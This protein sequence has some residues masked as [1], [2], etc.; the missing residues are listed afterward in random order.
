MD[1][2]VHGQQAEGPVRRHTDEAL[3]HGS[4]AQGGDPV[5]ARL[6]FLRN[7]IEA[8]ETQG[9]DVKALIVRIT[10]AQVLSLRDRDRIS[11]GGILGLFLGKADRVVAPE[12]RIR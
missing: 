7:G 9:H 1:S 3:P 5:R 4:K 11:A 6:R 8:A 2:I 12:D 10:F